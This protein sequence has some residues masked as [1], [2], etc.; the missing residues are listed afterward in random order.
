[1][2]ELMANTVGTVELQQLKQRHEQK[3]NRLPANLPCPCARQSSPEN[4]YP[5]TPLSPFP[6]TLSLGLANST[7]GRLVSSHRPVGLILLSCD[8]LVMV[9][10]LVVM[11]A[12]VVLLIRLSVNPC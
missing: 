6:F 10:D 1:M 5:P 8:W 11:V 9:V 12:S 2:K 3:V 7:V 4:P